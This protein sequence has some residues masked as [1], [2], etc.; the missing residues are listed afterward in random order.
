MKQIMLQLKVVLAL[1]LLA[2]L[3]YLLNHSYEQRQQLERADQLTA[4]LSA[5]LEQEKRNVF[6]INHQ[7]R[8]DMVGMLAAQSQ[9]QQQ[10]AAQNETYER[11]ESALRGQ[12]C[13]DQPLPV[14][15]IRL[16]QHATPS[17]Q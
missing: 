15:V 2:G 13:A 3:A 12:R 11:L 1:A 10:L 14:D 4:T 17:S 5:N 9:M 8:A 16:R 6:D 7:R